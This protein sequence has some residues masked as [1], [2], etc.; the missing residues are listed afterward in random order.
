M[1]VVR[2]PKRQDDVVIGLSLAGVVKVWT[3]SGNESR[4]SE[5]IYEN[6]F[7]PLRCSNPLKLVCCSYNL[8]TVLVISRKNWQIYDAGDFS[9]LCSIDANPAERWTGGDFLT[10]ERVV[11]WSDVGKGYL[12]KLPTK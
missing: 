12:Y 8:R 3:L 11:V 7:K 6:E 4:S 2:P 9:L 5:P 10:A 1:H